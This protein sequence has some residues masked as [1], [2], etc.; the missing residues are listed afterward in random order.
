MFTYWQRRDDPL[1]R[2]IEEVVSSAGG[3]EDRCLLAAAEYLCRKRAGEATSMDK[4]A[5]KYGVS[6]LCVYRKYSSLFQGGIRYPRNRV[7]QLL[8]QVRQR[9]GPAVAEEVESLYAV[10][11][12]RGALDGLKPEG[13]VAA[14]LYYAAKKHGL[15]YDSHRA[16]EEFGVHPETVEKNIV[17]FQWYLQG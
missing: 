13:V 4:I 10:L 1:S 14:L 17:L 11:K 16:A 2:C 12:S 15:R 9:Y 5:A 6:L 7:E 3:G 8:E